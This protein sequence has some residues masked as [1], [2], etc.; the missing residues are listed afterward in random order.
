MLSR[1]QR[2]LGT[3][4]RERRI[5]ALEDLEARPSDESAPALSAREAAFFHRLSGNPGFRFMVE[6]QRSW[7]ELRTLNAARVTLGTLPP[8]ERRTLVK[9]WVERGGGTESFFATEA[10]V[11]LDY[12]AGQ[13]PAGSTT[14]VICRIEQAVQRAQRAPAQTTDPA[15]LS[16]DT[17]LVRGEDA[18]LLRVPTS[19]AA[20]MNAGAGSADDVTAAR[21]VPDAEGEIEVLL[22]PAISGVLREAEAG[23]VQIWATCATPV[24]VAALR[25][26]G[27]ERATLQVL[28]AER[29]LDVAQRPRSTARR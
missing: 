5:P 27:H 2:L 15:S 6:V 8:H 25:T 3:A 22:A 18:T 7:C 1:F 23:E 12:I 14:A 28:V 19:V 17:A 26:A 11:L 4:V 9:G 24:C 21:L 10:D 16:D 29:V 13:V 20:A